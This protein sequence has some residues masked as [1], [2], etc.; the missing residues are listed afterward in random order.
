MIGYTKK[1]FML[2]FDHRNSFVKSFGFSNKLNKKQFELMKYYKKII[3]KGFL[4]ARK[5]M[6]D[7]SNLCILVDEYFG[8]EI[9]ESAR[10]NK[11]LFSASTEKSGQNYFDFEYGKDFSKFIENINPNFVKALVR[12][13][14]DDKKNSLKSLK[15]LKELNDFC[16]KQKR[17]FLIELLTPIKKNKSLI[18]AKSIYEFQNYGIDPDIWKIEAYDRKYDWEIVVKQI[19]NSGHRKS[20]AIIMLGRGEDVNRVKKWINI[21]KKIKDINGFAIG[22]TIFLDALLRFHKKQINEKDAISIIANRYLDFIKIWES[23]K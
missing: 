2:P 13:D 22:R 1:I 16:R 9:I 18:T 8:K 7:K 20:V 10:K 14:P 3:Y 4:L 5:N 12:Y 6:K 11:I 21:A 19:K 17:I 23:H 15:K